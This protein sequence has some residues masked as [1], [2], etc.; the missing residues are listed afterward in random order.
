M[1]TSKQELGDFGERAVA[2]NVTCPG[3]KKDERTF[4][5]LPANFKCADLVCDFCGYLAQVKS[6][7]VSDTNALPR[8]IPG[9]A[10]QPQKQRMDASIYFPLFVVLVQSTRNFA[11]YFLPK[12]LQTREMF[13]PRNPL[14]QTAKRAGWQGYR[15][16]VSKALGAPVRIETL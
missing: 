14:K 5:L 16:D 6:V 2:A 11:I 1:A 12:E 7:T 13:V 9:A 8:T 3:C 15:I 10:W 4:R